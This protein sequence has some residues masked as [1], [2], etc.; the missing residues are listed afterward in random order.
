[1]KIVLVGFRSPSL[2]PHIGQTLEDVARGR[3]TSIPDTIMDLVIED[4]SRVE[5]VF[6]TMSEDGVRSVVR[7][8]WVSFCSDSGSLAPEGRF[9]ASGTHPRAYGSFA[10]LLATY[11]RADHCVSLPEGSGDSR[12][13]QRKTAVLNGG[14]VSRRDTMLTSPLLQEDAWRRL[15]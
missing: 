6:F 3:G 9:L 1:M 7:L 11:V 15:Y 13:F 10:R 5:A 12:R 8:P 14:V 2:R 4:E